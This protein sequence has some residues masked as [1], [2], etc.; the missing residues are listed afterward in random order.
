MKIIVQ[1]FGGTSTRSIETRE[2]MYKNIIREHDKGNK[3]VAVVSAMG[4]YD[5]PYA[6][7]TLLSIVHTDQLTDEEIDRLTS[8]GETI[9]TLVV[10]SELAKKGY[11][12]DTVTNGELG[13]LTDSHHQNA[14]ITTVEGKHILDKLKNADIVICPGFQGYSQN[15]KITT[16]GRGGSDLSAVAIGVAIDAN[17]VEIYS[18]VNGIY[19]A[20]PRI[21][22]DA[23]KLNYI[24]Y[25]EMLELSKN[26]A[27][28]LN[29]RCVQLAAKH[30]IV[31]HAR[32]SFDESQGTY[33][34]GDEKI[35]K[36]HL[37]QFIISGIT[38]SQNEA[39]ITLVGVDAKVNG[40]GELF[41]KIADAN[42]NVN[43]FSQALV[44]GGRMD[45]S[46]IINDKDV[47]A[48]VEVINDLKETLQA[49]KTI[50]RG[51]IGKVA[52]IGVGI[53]N[54]KGMF[55]KVYNT[56][57]S[58]DINVEMT[59]CSEINISCY[60]D[61]DDVKRAQVLLHEAFLG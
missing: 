7:D 49:K 4:R 25:S 33:V 34:L 41:E 29:H 11:V 19:T 40:A 20:D 32:S 56:L 16:L 54:N 48:V 46:L 38:G 26:G 39:R 35:M 1:K 6:T 18:D 45:I 15:G 57:M 22:P 28:V 3:V 60:I 30:D 23:M 14:T 12:V 58:H 59:S 55:Q 5:D 8:I 31:I 9:S 42:V 43:V 36:D 50:V 10:K 51:N 53:K 2:H 27:K 13:I 47:P 52:V 61:R 21:V 24:S 37:N 17:E 44:G